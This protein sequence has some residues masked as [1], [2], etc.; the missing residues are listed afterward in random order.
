[1]LCPESAHVNSSKHVTSFAHVEIFITEK[2][3]HMPYIWKI[4]MK[5]NELCKKNKNKKKGMNPV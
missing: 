3:I 4:N 5:I 1:M 2:L